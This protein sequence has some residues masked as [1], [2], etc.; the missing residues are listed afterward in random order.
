MTSDEDDVNSENPFEVSRVLGGTTIYQ[1]TYASPYD[2]DLE[3]NLIV[4]GSHLILPPICVHTGATE[5]LVEIQK[6]TVFPSMKLVVVQKFCYVIMFMARSEKVRREKIASAL[7]VITTIGVALLVAALLFK[8]RWMAILFPTG[9]LIASLSLVLLNRHN[10][11]LKLVRYRAPGV[12]WVRGF[13]KS[14]LAQLAREKL[15]ALAE[16]SHAIETDTKPSLE[17]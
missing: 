8:G 1:K 10:L 13:S 3:G 11:P 7:S 2:F 12:Y 9:L 14:F 17:M 5:D 4:C 6:H 15:N 16:T